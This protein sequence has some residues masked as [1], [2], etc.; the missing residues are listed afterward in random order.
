VGVY[1]FAKRPM[2]KK[3]VMWMCLP[4]VDGDGEMELF[5]LDCD[6]WREAASP[7]RGRGRVTGRASRHRFVAVEQDVNAGQKRPRG[8]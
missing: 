1:L 4:V 3:R 2:M 6:R 8:L 5:L 7:F